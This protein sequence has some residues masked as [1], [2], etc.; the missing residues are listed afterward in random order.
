[1][2]P[3]RRSRRPRAGDHLALL[4]SILGINT[5]HD[6]VNFLSDHG[7]DGAVDKPLSCRGDTCV[8]HLVASAGADEELVRRSTSNRYL[9]RVPEYCS[10]DD[11]MLSAMVIGMSVSSIS[12]CRVTIAALFNLIGVCTPGQLCCQ[13][14]RRK[15]RCCFCRCCNESARCIVVGLLNNTAIALSIRILPRI[16]PV[17]LQHGHRLLSTIP[18]Q[19]NESS[20]IVIAITN[21]VRTTIWDSL[22][23]S[24]FLLS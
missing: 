3:F 16:T 19:L 14:Q 7:V 24:R 12:T 2:S 10:P 22:H 1:M 21:C 11:G 18:N 9:V 13:Q 6:T 23:Y 17:T 20:V 15:V 5:D 8:A 4:P